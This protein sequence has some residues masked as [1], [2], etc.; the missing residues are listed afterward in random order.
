MGLLC[1]FFLDNHS[2]ETPQ[3]VA[4]DITDG[5]KDYLD[6]IDGETRWGE[7]IGLVVD[8]F[9]CLSSDKVYEILWVFCKIWSS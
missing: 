8:M 1:E 7:W 4:Y 2:Y 5:Y 9:Y 3:L 6:W